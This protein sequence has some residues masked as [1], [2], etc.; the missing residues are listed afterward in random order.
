[1]GSTHGRRQTQKIIATQIKPNT[2]DV[3]TA[4]TAAATDIALMLVSN[5]FDWL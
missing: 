5:R 4:A 1:M 3:I 2:W